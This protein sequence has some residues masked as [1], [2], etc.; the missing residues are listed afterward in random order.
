MTNSVITNA[1]ALIALQN[2]NA[3]NSKLAVTQS[4][5]N[6]GLKVQ[7]AKDNAATWAIAQNQ[8]ADMNALESVKT[9]LNR[10]TSVADVALAAGQQISDILVE[11]RQKATAAADPSAS[12]AT[13]KAYNDEFQSLLKSL[14][15]FAD[16]AT[17]DGE[18]I[19]NGKVGGTRPATP[20]GLTPLDFLANA[21]ASETITMNRQDLSL[22]GL[23]LEL[24]GGVF[25]NLL[26]QADAEW[27]LNA[28]ETALTSAS[29]KLAEL[30]AQSKQIEKHTLFVTKL[31][32]SLEVGVGNLVDADMARESARLQALQV[33]QQLGAQAL[34]I[35]NQ[36][37]QI[38]LSL[39]KG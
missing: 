12:D 15:S 24:A 34:S 26:Q 20:A 3:T 39:F 38:I 28:V 23:G 32:D 27:A 14:Q 17:F 29:G 7:G 31:M 36:A 21:D 37:P 16:N 8:R 18:N 30:G 4:R 11:L 33:Q 1:S 9:S 35:A 10:A 2:L 25:P 6:T 13:R 19:L 22:E 5:V